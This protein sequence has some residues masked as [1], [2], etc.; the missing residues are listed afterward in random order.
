M[1][2]SGWTMRL[3]DLESMSGQMAGNTLGTGREM[4]WNTLAFTFGVTAEGTRDSTRMTR[5][6]AMECIPGQI[7]KCTQAGGIKANSMVWVSLRIKM[8]S[9]E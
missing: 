4:Q 2:D 5:S 1:R 3:M 8:A 9:R 7:I 6:M